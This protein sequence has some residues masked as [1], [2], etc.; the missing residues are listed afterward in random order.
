MNIYVNSDE[1]LP[2]TYLIGWSKLDKWYYGSETGL[3]KK[4]HPKNLWT[5]YYTSSTYVKS[6]RETYGE[7]DVIEVRRTFHNKEAAI[8]WEAAVLKRLKV[9]KKSKWLN[10]S[11]GGNSFFCHSV[12]NENPSKR[13]EVRQKI[14]EKLAGR[15]FTDKAR[16]NM[17]QARLGLHKGKSYEE[18]YGI[19]KATELKKIRS[20][21]WKGK[22]KTEKQIQSVKDAM[23]KWWRVYPPDQNPIVMFGLANYCKQHKL[24]I[25]TMSSIAYRPFNHNGKFRYHLG[26]RV[27]PM[28]SPEDPVRFQENIADNMIS[29]KKTKMYELIHPDGQKEVVRGLSEFSKKQGWPIGALYDVKDRVCANGQPRT[30]KG[31][32]VKTLP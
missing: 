4:A 16:E 15:I 9:T 14:S 7:P 25:S 3:A 26:Y 21:S 11:H 24:D 29:D 19:H 28:Q 2:Y 20:K 18:I 23:S 27:E 12:G 6:F 10:K 22:S 17:R 31:I 32:I 30:Y 1:Y 13:P 8:L 5:T